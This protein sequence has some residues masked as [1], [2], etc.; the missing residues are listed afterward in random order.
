MLVRL[1]WGHSPKIRGVG[2]SHRVG[3]VGTSR[4]VIFDKPPFSILLRHAHHPH[5][6]FSR[7]VCVESDACLDA[8]VSALLRWHS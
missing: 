7:L 2:W 1:F 5:W 6:T 4:S 8:E 3:V